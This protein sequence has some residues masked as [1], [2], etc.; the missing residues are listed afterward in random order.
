MKV[1]AFWLL[2]G[3]SILGINL[4]GIISALLVLRVL[5]FDI[6]LLPIIYILV[7]IILGMSA[8][9]F[10]FRPILR[11]HRD[12]H[13]YDANALRILVLRIPT[14]Q[15]RVCGILWLIGCVFVLF[16]ADNAHDS[17]VFGISALSA[18]ALSTF[19]SYCV[20]LRIIRPV[21]AQIVTGHEDTGIELPVGWRLFL[22]WLTMNFIPACDIFILQF[23]HN[24]A[25][26]GASLIILGF[27]IPV[28]FLTHV[29]ISSSITTP[30]QEIHRAIWQGRRGNHVR[31]PIYDGSEIGTLQSGFNELMEGIDQNKRIKDLL[32]HYVGAEVATQAM[33]RPPHLGGE[34]KYVAILFVDIIGSTEFA[35]NHSPEEVATELN[36]FFEIVVRVV[37]QHKG[38]INKFEGDAALIIFGAPSPL[39]DAPSQALATARELQKELSNGPLSC[40]IGVAAGKVMAGHIGG[41]Q[42]YE[43]TVIGDAVNEAARL[44][45]LAKSTPGGVLTTVSTLQESNEAEQARWVRLKSVELRGRSILTQLARPIR[46]TLAER[47]LH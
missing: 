22:C 40:G 10:I 28:S 9:W 41:S 25:S 23:S 47:R 33:A 18:G 3:S 15:S 7:T 27:S 20:A 35:M 17:A 19:M 2:Y 38:I 30:I 34:K 13:R 21:A 36:K 8:S 31:L 5:G 6:L 46:P 16:L 39:I 42:R 37:H 1:R 43:Y 29:L 14:L 24:P 44:T 32:N 12:P 11:W 45:E 4:G 26:H